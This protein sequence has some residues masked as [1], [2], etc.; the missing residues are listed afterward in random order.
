MTAN[1][2]VKMP[3]KTLHVAVMLLIAAGTPTL[4]SAQS[5]QS[6]SAPSGGSSV[7]GVP[8]AVQGFSQNRDK[9]I[10]IDAQS[11][12][13]RDKD[14]AATFTGNVKVVQGDTT[15]YC[16]VLVVS[17]EQ[18]QPAAGQTAMKSA[19]PG[20]GGSSSIRRLD[21]KGGVRVEQKDQI[22]TGETGV[23]DAKTNLI[24]VTNNV[25]L[26]QQQN[27]L[28]GDKL[29]VDMTT[30]VS[31]VESTS[32]RGVSGLFNT[33]GGNSGGAA[34][35]LSLGGGGGGGSSKPSPANSSNS[36]AASPKEP[37]PAGR[38]LDLNGLSSGGRR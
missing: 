17:Y 13:V 7:Q 16:K 36:N 31:R 4:A 27:V 14:K 30:G 32:G 28:K 11:L 23:F 2:V 33:S 20:P 38:P 6:G 15:M 26:T 3:R 5:K 37:V 12:E 22:V 10:R 34:S 19:A 18:S 21:A 1:L 29:V 35:P 9:P 8:N 24:T 25:V